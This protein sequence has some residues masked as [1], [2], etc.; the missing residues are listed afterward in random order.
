MSRPQRI[1]TR[2]VE[3]ELLE[4]PG[5]WAALT[6]RRIIAFGPDP[7]TVLAAAEA[8]GCKCPLLWYVPLRNM[9]FYFPAAALSAPAA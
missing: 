5:E 6:R 9:H 4:H 7:K 1:L 8:A 3:Q 2:A